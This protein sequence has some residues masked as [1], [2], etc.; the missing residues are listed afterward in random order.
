MTQADLP[1]VGIICDKEIIGPHPFHIVGEKYIKAIKDSSHCIP[2]LIPAMA[3]ESSII[4][5]L[6]MLDGL[7]LPGG[8]SMVDPLYYQDEIA[9]AGTKLDTARDSTSLPIIVKAV[10]QGIPILGICRGFQEINVAFG[11]SL[12]QKLHEKGHYFEHRENKTLTL[13]QQYSA[14]HHINV[15]ADGKLA[16][17]LNE[18]SIE[19]NSLHTQGV[20]RLA[21]NLT[22]EA[23]SEDGLIEAFSVTES[24]SFAMAVQWHPEWCVEENPQS[25]QLFHAFG[26]A[27]SERKLAKKT[28]INNENKS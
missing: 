22:I 3:D 12:H 18:S 10:A 15:I 20:D 17:I 13:E 28:I 27:C 11:G 21:E 25:K 6:S 14:S 7:L 8:Y 4:Q 9:E 16:V 24:K 19:V 23:I 2:I 5:L 1:L 26:Q